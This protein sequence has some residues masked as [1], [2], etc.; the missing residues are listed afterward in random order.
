MI[1]DSLEMSNSDQERLARKIV[2]FFRDI[3]QESFQKIL[4]SDISS[5]DKYNVTEK[6][7]IAGPK[8]EDLAE[9][10]LKLEKNADP[11]LVLAALMESNATHGSNDEVEIVCTGPVRIDSQMLSTSS[12]MEEIIISAK[13]SEKI[14]LVDYVVTD[15]AKKIIGILNQKMNE[16][17]RVVM[18]IDD[19]YEN[20]IHLGKCF[21]EHSLRRPE[22]FTRKESGK[23]KI[24][25]KVLIAGSHMLVTSANLTAL[26][27]EVNFELGIRTRGNVSKKMQ[28]IL[29]G[30]ISEGHF[31]PWEHW[32]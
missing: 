6:T 24:H 9:L 16:G 20:R 2:E 28:R 32:K 10:L 17:V 4:D 3:P 18:I 1:W 19:N 31:I 21:S 26:G 12:V 29:E 27:T 11:K 13:P 15:G 22:I 8:G 25:A 7:G 23:Y 30:M 5:I 14:F